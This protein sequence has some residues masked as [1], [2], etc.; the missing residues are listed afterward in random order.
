MTESNDIMNSYSNQNQNSEP[1]LV[2]TNTTLN[3]D[4]STGGNL[5][6]DTASQPLAVGTNLTIE[7]TYAQAELLE[8]Q[9]GISLDGS[10]DYLGSNITI[11]DGDRDWLERVDNNPSY[12]CLH[13]PVTAM[14]AI[15]GIYQKRRVILLAMAG[16]PK[17]I[18]ATPANL[19]L[20]VLTLP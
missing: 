15:A 5:T 2:A 13:L 18:R 10:D 1:L 4:A 12:S 3:Y 16:L 7:I 19:Y 9:L 11:I 20:L 14:T 8:Q 17:P 6:Y